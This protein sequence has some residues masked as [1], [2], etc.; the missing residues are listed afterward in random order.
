MNSNKLFDILT[1]RRKKYA[2]VR[3]DVNEIIRTFKVNAKRNRSIA[4][5]F[6]DAITSFSGSIPFL[7][8]NVVWF[9]VWIALNTDIL[10]G[11]EP[12]DPFPFGLLT[13]I[14][15]LEAILLSTAVLISQNRETKVNDLRSEIDARIDIVAE[16]KVTK[17]LELLT[18]LL[19]KNDVDVSNDE[20]LIKMLE[21]ED[22]EYLEREIE[23]Q[24]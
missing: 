4:D 10:P 12:F 9:T 5:R 3:K 16:E 23:K 19:K 2:K 7:V 17:C 21:P 8:I 13:M 14:V 15:S 11:M 6:A 24:V 20:T 22:K 18:L 1:F